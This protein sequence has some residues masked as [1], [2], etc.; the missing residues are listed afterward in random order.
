MSMDM[1]LRDIVKELINKKLACEINAC[2]DG[3]ETRISMRGALPARV[4]L[5]AK[6]LYTMHVDE[7][8]PLD[9]IGEQLNEDMRILE[10]LQ[11]SGGMRMEG[12][13]SHNGRC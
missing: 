13:H 5:V 12:G 1:D 6:I 7:K 10:E 11:K 3:G 9:S 2:E 4:F 8:I